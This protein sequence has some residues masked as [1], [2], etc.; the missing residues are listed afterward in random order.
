MLSRIGFSRKKKEGKFDVVA[1]SKVASEVN[2]QFEK[3]IFVRL[4]NKLQGIIR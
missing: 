3:C 4:G 2:K 1:L